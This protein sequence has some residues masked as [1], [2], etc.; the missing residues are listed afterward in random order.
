MGVAI[1]RAGE[2]Q[3]V[4]RYRPQIVQ[5]AAGITAA[6]LIIVL[7]VSGAGAALSLRRRRG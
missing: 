1:P 7:L 3:V 2:H 5:L 6:T 4:L